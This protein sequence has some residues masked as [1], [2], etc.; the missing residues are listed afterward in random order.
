MDLLDPGKLAVISVIA[1]LVLGPQRLGKTARQ[2]GSLWR[3]LGEH[4][5]RFE[6][7]VHRGLNDAGLPDPRTIRPSQSFH[8]AFDELI[9]PPDP[10]RREAGVGPV[11]EVGLAPTADDAL[12]SAK[13]SPEN[14]DAPDRYVHDD[15]SMN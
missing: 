8:R 7:E 1:L 15:A 12:P 3:V 13:P 10:S 11:A 14:S 9:S 4:R 2:M 6:A 5:E